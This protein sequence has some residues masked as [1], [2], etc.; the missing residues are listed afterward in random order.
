M[1]LGNLLWVRGTDT[2]GRLTEARRRWDAGS[3]L[4]ALAGVVVTIAAGS[5]IFYNTNI[6]NQYQ[7]PKQREKLQARYE[8]QYRRLRDVAQPRI[9]AVNLNTDIYPGTRRVHFQGQFMLVNKHAR[10][11]DTVIVSLP[12]A[13][14]PRVRQLALG[15]P[16]AATLVL[17]DSTL[18]TRLYRL[19]RPLAPGD[20]LPLSLSLDYRELGFPNSDPNTDIVGNGSFISSGYLPSLGYREGAELGSDQ[21]RKSYG[22]NTAR[23]RW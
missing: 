4:A 19:A 7:T 23:A 10:P 6:L 9:V 13:L 12:A 21:P 17:N 1:L 2:T 8:K 3:T 5:F 20:S 18:G 11:L 16:G 15:Q 14:H 22:L